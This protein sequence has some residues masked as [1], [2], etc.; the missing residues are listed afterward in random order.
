MGIEFLNWLR[1]PHIWHTPSLVGPL[2]LS[3]SQ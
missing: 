2:G 3:M 1:S